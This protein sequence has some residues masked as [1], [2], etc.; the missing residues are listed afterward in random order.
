MA[1]QHKQKHISNKIYHKVGKKPL[2]LLSI[3]LGHSPI[4]KG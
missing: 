3:R 4:P 2:V 1:T